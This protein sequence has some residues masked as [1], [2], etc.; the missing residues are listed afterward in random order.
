MSRTIPSLLCFLVQ[1]SFGNYSFSVSANGFATLILQNRFRGLLTHLPWWRVPGIEPSIEPG[2]EPA[3]WDA[4]ESAFPV[5]DRLGGPGNTKGCFWLA[6]PKVGPLTRTAGQLSPVECKRAL[7]KSMST[8]SSRGHAVV[9]FSCPF[10][11]QCAPAVTQGILF[12]CLRVAC[13]FG[14]ACMREL[15]YNSVVFQLLG[16]CLG[17][18]GWHVVLGAFVLGK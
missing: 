3:P 7:V 9:H 12:G 15:I 14:C 8:G 5:W 18:S 17:V 1:S 6:A 10:S 11:I 16:C 13:G 2:I 4:L